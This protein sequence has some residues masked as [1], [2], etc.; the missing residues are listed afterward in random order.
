MWEEKTIVEIRNPEINKTN[1]LS[2]SN[3]YSNSGRNLRVAAPVAQWIE[4]LFPKQKVT[5]STPVW[6]EFVLTIAA[7]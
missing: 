5:G 6:R 4:R 7:T 3:V 1:L 2:N